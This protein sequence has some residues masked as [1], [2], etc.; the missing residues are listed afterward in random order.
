MKL[1]FTNKLIIVLLSISVIF[2]IYIEYIEKNYTVIVETGKG[3]W[4]TYDY[5]PCDSVNFITKKEVNFW[6]NGVKTRLLSENIIRLK[7]N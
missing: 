1:N 6:N 5:I 3:I 2:I 4:K 7:G